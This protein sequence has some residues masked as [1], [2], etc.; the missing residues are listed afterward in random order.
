VIEIVGRNPEK[1]NELLTDI[2]GNMLAAVIWISS[3]EGVSMVVRIVQ[4]FRNINISVGKVFR[5]L[6]N[7]IRNVR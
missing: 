7:D 6:A 5:Q 1:L 4:C 3:D 2:T